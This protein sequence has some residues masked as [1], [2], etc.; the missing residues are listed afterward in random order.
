[1]PLLLGRAKG[2]VDKTFVDLIR[3]LAPEGLAQLTNVIGA[4]GVASSD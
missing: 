4:A 2:L 1:V 3:E